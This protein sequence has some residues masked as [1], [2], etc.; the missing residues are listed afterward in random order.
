[1]GLCLNGNSECPR[2]YMISTINAYV[3]RALT[4]CSS[5]KSVHEELERLTQVLVNNGYPNS[6]IN[7]A[8]NRTIDKWNQRQEDN[9]SS[10]NN[11]K[12]YYRSYMSSSYKTDERV[13]KDIVYNNVKPTNPDQEIQLVIYY[14]NTKTS[15][16]LIKNNPGRTKAPLKE[17][18][19]IYEHSC[20]I[21]GC[22]SQSYIGMTRTTLSRRLTCHLQNGA[23]KNHYTTAHNTKLT[24]KNLEEGTKKIDKETD[25][26][27]LLFLEALHIAATS[28]TI[29]KQFQDLQVLPTL[30][31]KTGARPTPPQNMEQASSS[32]IKPPLAQPIAKPEASNHRRRITNQS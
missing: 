19:V 10:K 4:H 12:L 21:E 18:H 5:W 16:L 23:I 26:R 9:K 24:R 8:I 3:R 25:S 28:P 14:K 29:N 6:D 2:R 31:R 20:T 1:M 22:G 15:H 27:R 13:I 30:K 32:R 7:A 17:D 11:I